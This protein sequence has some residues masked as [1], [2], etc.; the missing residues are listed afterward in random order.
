MPH[1]IPISKH[2]ARVW[3]ETDRLVIGRRPHVFNDWWRQVLSCPSPAV[4]LL[5]SRDIGGT[6]NAVQLLNPDNDF[7]WHK[8]NQITMWCS[9]EYKHIMR[10]ARPQI[11]RSIPGMRFHKGE[12]IFY[13]PQGGEVWTCAAGDPAGVQQILGLKEPDN[14]IFD[15]PE[16]Y[17]PDFF[18]LCFPNF[19]PGT[20][21]WF[22]GTPRAATYFNE[23]WDI[24]A[25][26]DPSYFTRFEYPFD[27]R[28]LPVK[29][30]HLTQEEWDKKLALNKLTLPE[31]LYQREILMQWGAAE[32]AV[33]RHVEAARSD[34]T[35]IPAGIKLA[36]LIDW[37]RDVD[38]VTVGLLGRIDDKIVLWVVGRWTKV[39]YD[40][41]LLRI[42]TLIEP[43]KKQ[44]I[45]CWHD[46]TGGD[47]KAQSP[48]LRAIGLTV[49]ELIWSQKAG[50]WH[51]LKDKMVYDTSLIF[52]R[53][54]YLIAKTEYQDITITE[55]LRYMSKPAITPGRSTYAAPAGMHD[56]TVSLSLM[57]VV[58]VNFLDMPPAT[59]LHIPETTR[60]PSIPKKYKS[61]YTR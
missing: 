37:A 24:I 41:S 55:H 51:S 47:G 4:V 38:Y 36:L 13:P 42:A 52:D 46:A 7:C 53:E 35:N 20:R 17:H 59:T 25:P 32:G 49:H 28:G 21:Q 8:P 57:G 1:R 23:L 3:R 15:E 43:Y 9:F 22:G 18:P 29:P 39:E 16:V 19:R 30:P 14:W 58:A 11:M 31:S 54:Q 34:I 12:S 61:F 45:G 5:K 48:H 40:E 10:T 26:A 56:D 27:N 33:F 50:K 6:A 60:L 2:A 44:I